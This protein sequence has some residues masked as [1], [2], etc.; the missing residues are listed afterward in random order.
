MKQGRAYTHRTR[1][2]WSWRMEIRENVE[3]QM[4]VDMMDREER[5]GWGSVSTQG[6]P[7]LGA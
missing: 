5:G 3:G 7:L 2:S 4:R 6:W 1:M